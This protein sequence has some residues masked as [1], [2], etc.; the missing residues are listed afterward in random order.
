MNSDHPITRRDFV[1]S[2]VGAVVGASAL[3]SGAAAARLEQGQGPARPGRSARVV[4][5]RDA[6]VLNDAHDVDA[7]V[8]DRMLA[9]TVV[10]LTGEKTPKAAWLALFKP[11]DTVGLVPTP[12]LNPTHPELVDAVRRA[13]VGAGIPAG[14][15]REAQGGI[16]RPRACTALIAM[17]ALKAHWLTGLGTAMKIYIM[18]SGRPSSY[19]DANNA[20]LAETWLLPDVK[21]KTKL[22]LV[23]ALRPLCDKGPQPDPRYLWDYKGLI[24]SA[25]PVAADAVGLQIVLAKRRALRGEEWPLSPPPLCVSMADEKFGLGTSRM[26][27]IALDRVGWTGDMFI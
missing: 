17:P 23:D 21:G 15:V 20:N 5:V 11:S 27:E 4:I 12:H 16:D 6:R 19:H 25:D 2:A 13:L 8:L 24:A 1:R 22:V 18:Y 26:S 14:Q 3:G 9:D 7:A 10:R